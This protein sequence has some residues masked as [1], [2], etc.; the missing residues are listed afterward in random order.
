MLTQAKEKGI[1]NCA[2]QMN[3]APK[4]KTAI[5]PPLSFG[6]PTRREPRAPATGD[7]A[8]T[9]PSAEEGAGR[10]EA[11][12]CS[13]A[14][15]A[16]LPASPR[17]RRAPVPPCF[18]QPRLARACGTCA[19]PET[20][21][22]GMRNALSADPDG[23]RCEIRTQPCQER[24]ASVHVRSRAAGIHRDFPG[25]GAVLWERHDDTEKIV[26]V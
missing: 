19:L 4:E 13:A 16:W 6:C 26:C 23:M 24:K 5:P 20:A 3:T 8:V 22:P 7:A 11:P 18:A 2:V 14:G 25:A 17:R 10:G 15:A 1:I 21:A 9:S 12:G